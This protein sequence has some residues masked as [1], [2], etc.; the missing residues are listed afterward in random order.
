MTQQVTEPSMIM[1]DA[2]RKFLHQQLMQTARGAL[3]ALESFNFEDTGVS[4]PIGDLRSAIEAA[5]ATGAELSSDHASNIAEVVRGVGFSFPTVF[6]HQAYGSILAHGKAGKRKRL[7]AL[8]RL[9][10]VLEGAW[11][12][13]QVYHSMAE[14]EARRA[15]AAR[16]LTVAEFVA[17]EVQLP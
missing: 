11:L 15:H 13:A 7:R 14:S 10:E 6:F 9:N 3:V 17:D 8:R 5:D 2:D 4:P 12:I 16:E 1:T